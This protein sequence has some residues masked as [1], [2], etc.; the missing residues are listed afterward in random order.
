MKELIKI[1]ISDKDHLHWPAFLLECAHQAGPFLLQI[2][3]QHNLADDVDFLAFEEKRLVFHSA[4]FGRMSFDFEE[5]ALYHQR[6]HYALTKEPLAKALGIKGR[7]DS[8][9]EKIEIWDATCG[10]GKDLTLIHHFGAQLTAFERNP[11]IYLLLRDALQR[12]PMDIQL[13]FGDAS[14]F[15]VEEDKRPDVIYYDPMYPTK[16]KSALPRKEMRIFKEIVGDDS[17]AE[18]FLDWALGIARQRVVVKRPL[19]APAIK[20]PP[21]ASY[22]GKSTRYDMYRIL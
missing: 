2:E 12:Y 13:N 19:A 15:A 21:T 11:V 18:E 17:D 5:L 3:P 16:K 14:A 8:H 20:H 9:Q 7:S 4:E 1:K 10:T 22:I 6:Q